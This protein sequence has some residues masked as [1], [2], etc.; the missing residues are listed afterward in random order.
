MER[1]KCFYQKVPKN[2]KNK[3]ILG[4]IILI[5]LLFFDC[6]T[7]EEQLIED[8][9]RAEEG[10]KNDSR[11]KELDDLCS[12]LPKHEKFQLIGKYKGFNHVG[13]SHYYS[14]PHIYFEEIET[15]YDK[16]FLENG[17]NAYP[18]NGLNGRKT[19]IFTKDNC[20]IDIEESLIPGTKYSFTCKNLTARY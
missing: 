6:K 12:Q 11:I 1:E 15:F 7:T 10:I 5:S 13:I 18:S 14:S 8:T 9:K 3:T 4:L 19:L 16:Y 2:C 20:E 17:W